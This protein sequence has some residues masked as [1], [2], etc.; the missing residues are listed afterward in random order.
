M[1]SCK[2]YAEAAAEP[3]KKTFSVATD[4]RQWSL[5]TDNTVKMMNCK[6]VEGRENLRA[7]SSS[8]SNWGPP[9]PKF[10][11]TGLILMNFLKF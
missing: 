8:Y 9:Y 2:P 3:K 4:F 11:T 6:R 7:S 1:F 10:S 5:I